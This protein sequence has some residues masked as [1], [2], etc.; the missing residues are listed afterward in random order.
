MT[1]VR[2]IDPRHSHTF[3]LTLTHIHFYIFR[4]YYS[5]SIKVFF[6]LLFNFSV[7]VNFFPHRFFF[8]FFQFLFYHYLLYT[9]QGKI[10]QKERKKSYIYISAFF[11]FDVVY[12]WCLYYWCTLIFILWSRQMIGMKDTKVTWEKAVWPKN[13]KK[14][15]I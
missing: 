2:T 6:S 9:V 12:Y 4:N 8:Y 14:K 5:Y 13:K 10:Y 15:Y 1:T 3:T 11:V 7:L